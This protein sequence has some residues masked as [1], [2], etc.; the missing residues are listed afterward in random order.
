MTSPDRAEPVQATSLRFAS[1]AR[2]LSAAGRA[3]S[4]VVP[5]FRSPPRMRGAH[6]TLRRRAEGGATVSV[7]LRGRPW[8]AVLADMIDGVVATNRLAGTDAAGVRAR[9]WSAA[10]QASLID[11][12]PS[13][14]RPFRRAPPVPS[15]VSRRQ[16]PIPTPRDEAA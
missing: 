9:L 2:V 13:P 1:A 4:L 14:D 3:E 10:E 8:P 15:S 12:V 5:S 7:V 6:R 11:S 16:Q